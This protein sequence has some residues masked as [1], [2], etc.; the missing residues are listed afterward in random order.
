MAVRV[1]QGRV[2]QR[3]FKFS[4]MAVEVWHALD[5][6][7]EGTQ[8]SGTHENTVKKALNPKPLNSEPQT[9]NQGDA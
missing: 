3:L 5:R 1:L 4:T 2:L 8:R 7:E 9:L 6:F